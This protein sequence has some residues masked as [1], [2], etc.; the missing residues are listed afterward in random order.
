MKRYGQVCPLARGLD[1]IGDRW[2]LLIVRELMIGPRRYTD[3]QAGLPGIGTNVLAARLRDLAEAGIVAHRTLP[4]P[5]PASLYELT[6]AGRAL[7]PTIHALQRWGTEHAPP[8][9]PGD[10]VRPSWVLMNAANTG[11]RVAADGKVCQLHVGDEVF[12]LAAEPT[13]F[14]VHGGPADRADATVTTDRPTFFA[15][16]TG[17]IDVAAIGAGSIGGDTVVANAFLEALAGSVLGPPQ[18]KVER[19]VTLGHT[20]R[21]AP[22]TIT[23]HRT[24]GS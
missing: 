23:V 24:S 1:V 17:H 19:P 2:N 9:E 14:S 13:G 5:T 11:D 7:G 22:A 21:S 8:P 20:V 15:L 6:A 12:H 18:A 3:L 4:A 10:A 16:A